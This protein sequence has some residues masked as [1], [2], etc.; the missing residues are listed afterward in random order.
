MTRIRGRMR[1]V[2]L[3]LLLL[4]TLASPLSAYEYRS[5]T[6][7]D[8]QIAITT[9]GLSPAQRNLR[10]KV[11][12]VLSGGG[13]RGFA[14]IPIIEAVERAGIPIDM[15]LGTS[16]GSLVGGLYAA[17]YSPGDMRRLIAAYDM[18]ELFALSALPPI[19]LDPTPLRRNRDNLFIIG[20]DR[21]GLGT[22]SGILGDQRILQML[23][24]S[25][26]RVAGIV[27]FDDLA[28]P[29]RCIGTDLVTGEKII[30]S[31]GSLVTAIRASISIPLVF[32]PY[33]VDGRMVIDGGLV[34]N[35]PINLAKEMGADIVIAV[36]VNAVDYDVTAQ[37]LESL[38]SILAQL[39]V[40]LTKN[41][42]V[43]QVAGADLLLKPSLLDHGL[44]D[45]AE[46][47][48][49]LVVGET[50]AA[51]HLEDFS[52]I[53]RTIGTARPLNVL[54]PNRYGPYFSLPDVFVRTVSHRSLQGAQFESKA[55]FD[56]S[57]FNRFAGFPLDSMRKSQLNAQFDELRL[58]GNYATVSYDYTDASL[59]RSGS[60]WGN[61]EIQTRQFAPRRSSVSAGVFGTLSFVF[62]PEETPSFE[63]K[64]D[65][66]ISYSLYKVFASPTTWSVRVSNDD[67]LH[68]AN[69][70][71]YGFSDNWKIGNEIS[72]HSGGLHPLNLRST[73]M[74]EQVQD[75]MLST[76]IILQHQPSPR[77]LIQTVALFD[78]LWF[79]DPLVGQGGFLPSVHLESVYS[80]MPF[81]FFPHRGTRMDLSLD[82]E[83]KSDLGYK[84]ESRLQKVFPIGDRNALWIDLHGGLSHI[85]VPRKE[86]YFDFGGSRGMPTYPS[87]TLVDDMLLF[88]V[89]HLHWFFEKPVGLIL[90]SML[91]VGS[92]GQTVTGLLTDD[93]TL[94]NLGTPF[95]TFGPLEASASVAL[96]FSFETLD[97]LF[98]CAIDAEL[99]VSVFLEVL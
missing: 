82:A 8:R 97:L 59:G 83:F 19:P 49:I 35:M 11:A 5:L 4:V 42:V 68:V 99:N 73:F 1:A 38:T 58:S 60:V 78:Y 39:V 92:Y 54:D 16:M 27:D 72:Y 56:L 41:T 18:V 70:L 43:D 95:S 63:F 31:S 96:G 17:G 76:E 33:P 37:E 93:P 94:T 84:L 87:T 44:L 24:D 32:T 34:D 61:L 36:D 20:F 52:R 77:F 40:I 64:P 25:L 66:S 7:G 85:H 81:G 12:L 48:D 98:G 90:Q 86:S 47:D 80:T 88:R 28:I 13:A 53:A 69:L 65:F 9:Y 23:N 6:L 75:R 30:F 15:V 26:S 79:G 74:D 67:A 3:S 45:F 2:L 89:K 46:V 29:F 21:G 91:T 14:H 57:Q 10:P 51:L 71:M 55:G 22:A 50:E 62:E